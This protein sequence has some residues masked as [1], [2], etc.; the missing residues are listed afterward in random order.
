ML[1]LLRADFR[2]LFK[3]KI[4]WLECALMFGMAIYCIV[5]T[6]IGNKSAEEPTSSPDSLVIALS[7]ISGVLSAV[8]AAFFIGTEHSDGTMRN[9]LIVGRTRTQIYFAGLIVCSAAALIVN[10]V[11]IIT[12]SVGG[13]IFI[14]RFAADLSAVLSAILLSFISDIAFAAVALFGA[15]MITNK[16]ASVAVL[17]VAAFLL[18]AYADVVSNRLSTPEYFDAFTYADSEGNIHE[19]PRQPNASYPTGA[20]RKY[21]E[22]MYDTL[23]GCQLM[24]T[25]NFL[26]EAAANG[27]KL[28]KEENQKLLGFAGTSLIIVILATGAGVILFKRK[29]LK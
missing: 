7:A 25:Q 14:G 22:F 15:M 9:K 2:R 10:L 21:Y 8:F 24:Q 17:T 23:P 3:N 27:G 20:K 11:F 12:L 5:G 28:A 13:S 19:E 6:L 16:A 18:F 26:Y 4:F 29:D 1:E